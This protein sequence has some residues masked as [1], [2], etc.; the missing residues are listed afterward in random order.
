MLPPTGTL[1]D[2]VKKNKKLAFITSSNSL[3][4]SQNHLI[5]L[6]FSEYP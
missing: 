6:E 2:P 4:T 5:I 3:K 1:K